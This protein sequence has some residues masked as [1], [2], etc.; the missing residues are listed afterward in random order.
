[1]S[2]HEFDNHFS[3][4]KW[5]MLY[6]NVPYTVYLGYV[7]KKLKFFHSWIARLDLCNCRVSS[8]KWKINVQYWKFCTDYHYYSFVSASLI[9]FNF[10]FSSMW[11]NM[12][13]YSPSISVFLFWIAC[14]KACSIDTTS[15]QVPGLFPKLS[16]N[17]Y[18]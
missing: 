17:L 16:I 18:S 14:N 8:W 12:Q 5:I 10:S 2:I 1:M 7:I 15:F 9:L 4:V 3:V 6:P 11:H 13:C